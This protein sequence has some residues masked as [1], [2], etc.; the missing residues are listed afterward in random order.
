MENGSGN[1]VDLS[2]YPDIAPGRKPFKTAYL[3]AMMFFV[4]R[5]FPAAYRI[6]RRVRGELDGLPAGFSFALTV[7][8]SI[9]SGSVYRDGRGRLRAG[10]LENDTADVVVRFRN[11]ESAF[12]VFS[13]QC[14][15]FESYA[16]NGMA[17]SGDLPTTMAFMRCLNIVESYL[18]PGIITK[19]ILKREVR[20]GFGQR[21]WGRILVYL[22]VLFG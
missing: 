4:T 15:A 1:G 11:V 21:F 22:G 2:R 7:A 16:K 20:F 12:D 3:K 14:G 18:L 13:F 9:A 17:V 6:D 19:K 8:P 10:K 5:A